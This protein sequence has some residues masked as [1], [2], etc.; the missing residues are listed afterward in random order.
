MGD[1]VILAIDLG[2]TSFKA[3]VYD[4][5]LRAVWERSAPVRYRYGS[6]GRVELVDVDATLRRILPRRRD[7]SVIAITSQAQTFTVR[8]R[9]FISWQDGRA[10]A[11]AAR[12]RRRLPDFAEH[13][14]FAEPLPALLVSQLHHAPVRRGEWV[15]PLPTYFVN[16]WIGEPVIDDNL[17]AMTGL[18]SLKLHD[19]WSPACGEE[20]LPRVIPVGTVAGLTRRN[21]FGLPTGVPVVLAGNDQTAGAFGARLEPNGGTLVT[22][23]TAQVAYRVTRRLTAAGLVRGPYPDGLA[24]ELVAD[25]CGGNWI[26]WA[27]ANLRNCATPDEFFAAA[28]QAPKGC[29]GLEFD[30][31]TGTWRGL[32][33]HHNTADLARSILEGLCRQLA[34]QV[35][36]LT[37]RRRDRIWVAGGGAQR[38]LWRNMLARELGQPVQRCSASPLLGAARMAGISFTP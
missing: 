7:L 26:S 36:Q 24:Y 30:P 21:R 18:Y 3:G 22:L 6:G 12:L 37:R 32:G 20:R 4:H 9:P 14:S 8:G 10:V 1:G 28:A 2:S 35:R 29:C 27:L 11:A 5:R 15:L 25:G 13:C 38:A 33:L 19:W 34:G 23:G 17:A 16:E 31:G